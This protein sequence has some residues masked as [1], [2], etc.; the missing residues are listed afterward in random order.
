MRKKSIILIFL[1]LCTCWFGMGHANHPDDDFSADD[2]H[3]MKAI[4]I[5]ADRVVE[6]FHPFTMSE[7]RLCL[8]QY[9]NDS[10]QWYFPGFDTGWGFAVY[11][12]PEDC[13]VQNPYPF[14]IT[15]VHLYL[16]DFLG[17]EW[18]VEIQVNL[19]H[20][21]ED[22]VNCPDLGK[23]GS[24]FPLHRQ[25]FTIPIDSSYDRLEEPMTLSLDS[26]VTPN[27]TRCLDT[28]FFL[29]IIFTG[30]TSM[31]FPSLMMTDTLD[32]AQSCYDW[33]F[34]DGDYHEWYDAW[35][36]PIPGN[37]IIRATGYTH[38]LDCYPCWYWKPDTTTAPSGVPDFDQNQ[39]ADS[40]A[41]SIPAA[42][43]N[44]LWWL[45]A[46]PEGASPSDLITLLLTYFGTDPST[47]TSVDSLQIGLDRYFRDFVFDFSEYTYI[48]PDFYEM[49]DS[50]E[51]SQNIILILGFWQ[52]YGDSWHRFG[53]H[54]VSLAGVC[55]ESLWIGVSDPAVDGA[56]LG[57]QGRSF[58]LLH[59]PHSDDDTLHNNSLYVSHDIYVSDTLFVDYGDNLDTLW[60]IRD[61]YDADNS[62]FS[63]F[64]GKN[65]HPGQ[66]QYQGP[67]VPEQP[68][69]TG[70]E[71]AVVISPRLPDT[72][73]YWKPDRLAQ[74]PAAESG[75]PDFD[76]YQFSPPDSQALCGPTAIGNCLWWLGEVPPETEPPEL[77]RLLSDHFHSDFDS[78]TCVDSIEAGLDSLF[79]HYGI[80]LY[81][82]ILEN[83]NFSEI[84]DSLK[85]SWNI[86][87]LLGFWQWVETEPEVGDW[88]RIGGHFLTMAGVCSDSFKVAF[89]DPARDDAESGG[90]GRVRPSWHPSHPDDPTYHNN[91]IN[92]SH[93]IYTSGILYLTHDETDTDTLWW[94]TDYYS[95][96]DTAFF[97][98]FEGQNFQPGQT[99]YSYEPSESVFTVVEY[100]IMISPK[101]TDVEEEGEIITFE[102]FQLFQNH[103]NPFNNE[104]IIKYTLSKSSHVSLVIYNILGQKV[105]TLVNEHQRP[106]VKTVSWD[107]KDEKGKGLSSGIYLYKLKSREIIQTKR[108][109][110]LK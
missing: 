106:G 81:Q 90:V 79:E 9:D 47:G 99:Q 8:I 104:T 72:L 44:C 107:G 59:P 25:T 3:K 105:R 74:E 85:E 51:E 20:L 101:E 13:E 17:A 27:F 49:V 18:P 64:E 22:T 87:L 34:Y 96:E 86:G 36:L 53:G 103:P 78:G 56:E 60:R 110:L 65:F 23:P 69:Y 54:A 89:S 76:Q 7:G 14:K 63:K 91:P 61:F 68:V 70:V 10:P 16:D 32:S 97:Y 1:V 4:P 35:E 15:F 43:A 102:D 11:M 26:L 73:W 80:N 100:A 94:I 33:F 24:T 5:P 41:L 88:R 95:E 75:V 39:F 42:V 48:Q 46:V 58:P 77:I 2:S 52:F 12:D 45:D 108:M 84:G 55:S 71:Y 38:C 6:P 62:L 40:S 50:I 57:W 92:V 67:Y 37:P 93:D 21:K 31:P 98:Q 28:T 29:E 19:R 82:N 66:R 83:P 30:G 109:L